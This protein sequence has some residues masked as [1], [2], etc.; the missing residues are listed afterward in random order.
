MKFQFLITGFL[1]LTLETAFAQKGQLTE[2]QDQLSQYQVARGQKLLA[3]QAKI[4]LTAAKSAI[5]KASGNAKTSALPLTYALK[6]AIYANIADG[7]SV[8]ATSAVSYAT[9]SDALKQAKTLD[10]KNEN[11]KLIDEAS[12]E[13]AQY[14]LTQG[15]AAYQNKKFDDAYKAFDMAHQFLPSDTTIMFNSAIAA[16][17]AKNYAGAITSYNNLLASSIYTKKEDVYS[18]IIPLYLTNK[19]TV[20]ALKI[21]NEAIVKYP[22][23]NSLRREGIEIALQSGKTDDVLTSIKSAIQADPKNKALYYYEGLTYAQLGD[24]ARQKSL[25]IKDASGNTMVQTALDNYNNAAEAL[26]QAILIDPNY[27]E[28]QMNLGYVLMQPAIFTYNTANQLPANQQ[29]QYT[30]MKNKANEQ[31]DIAKPYLLKAVELK[32]N[33]LEALS[34]LMNYYRGDSDPA[35]TAEYK[36]KAAELKKQIDALPAK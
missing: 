11:T 17:N 3:A 20:S 32:P 15:V 10:T 16:S 1:A 8:L 9:A 25:K 2:A 24:A 36:T 18:N 13:L 23:N 12:R 30:A 14:S 34:N 22:T 6:A 33:S 4:N 27:F 29:K 5:D 28:A 19:D 7:D 31:F 21:V 26:K 35:H